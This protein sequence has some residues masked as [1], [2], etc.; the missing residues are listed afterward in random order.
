ME[1]KK[2]VSPMKG[3]KISEEDRGENAPK[4]GRP[5]AIA[6]QTEVHVVSLTLPYKYMEH[7]L[8]KHGTKSKADAIRKELQS[9]S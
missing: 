8:R 6:E 5:F 7:L 3:R 4:L 2:R 9:K 1:K